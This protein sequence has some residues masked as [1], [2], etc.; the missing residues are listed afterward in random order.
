M[1]IA[2]VAFMTIGLAVLGAAPAAAQDPP[3]L[4]AAGVGRVELVPD[5]A[6]IFLGVDRV[7]PT[8]RAARAFVNR[9]IARVRRAILAR[10][11]AAEDIQTTGISV[12]RERIRAR[13]GRPGRTRYHASSRLVV[14]TRDVPRVG[15][16]IDSV[17]DAGADEV[18]GP[19]FS[20][21]DPTMGDVLATRAAIADARRRADDAAAQI[22]QRVTGVQSVDL[23][24]FTDGGGP[25]R[26]SGGS[27]DSDSGGGGEGATR[28]LPGLEEFVALVRVVYTI[29]PAT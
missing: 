7:R 12:T 13:R 21:Q 20:F 1:R 18:F 9:R 8:S 26:A 15:A 16:L 4:A 29:A 6:E 5:Q 11:I 17:A 24:P 19:E 14:T 28:V 10:G 27:D 22:G 23:A 3:T 25:E 2:T